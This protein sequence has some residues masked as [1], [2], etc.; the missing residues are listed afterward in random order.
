[1]EQSYVQVQWC[2]YRAVEPV[3][4][5]IWEIPSWKSHK[6]DGK[7]T[8]ILEESMR[9]NKY[10]SASGYCSRREADRL[11]AE[12]RI[13]I[14][15]ETAVLGSKVCPGQKVCVDG[16]M[17]QNSQTKIL[18]AMNKPVG[19]VCTSSSRE[20]DNI[21]DYLHF[22]HRIYPVGRLDKE[23][24]GLILLTNDGELT[25]RILRGR[26]GHEKE[27]IVEVNKR[28]KPEILQAMRQGVP[29][30][31][32]ITKPCD[33]YRLDDRRFRSIL[34][35]GLNRQI[36]RM[37]EYFGYKV[38]TLKRVR[39][40]NIELGDLPEGAW[41]PVTPNEWEELEKSLKGQKFY[42]EGIRAD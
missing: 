10:L 39:I 41:R 31:D 22:E 23:S 30:L 5:P 20:K 25:D 21:V 32:T 33:I 29:I 28:L 17:I 9:I 7:E 6:W 14:D 27:Y 35:Q 11:L 40:M 4:N 37:C 15:G 26:N 3:F 34:T 16:R 18:I 8:A 12:G 42:N 19:I 36:R 13:T 38:V 24:T 2:R 1:M